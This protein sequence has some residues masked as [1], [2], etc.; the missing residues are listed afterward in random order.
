M[1][2]LIGT[3]RATPRSTSSTGCSSAPTSPAATAIG[4]HGL[5]LPAATVLP[6]GVHELPVPR[7]RAAARLARCTRR[8]GERDERGPDLPAGDGQRQ[9]H[10]RRPGDAGHRRR[11]GSTG[12][13]ASTT[14]AAPQDMTYVAEEVP[15]LGPSPTSGCSRP[16]VPGASRATRRAATAPPTSRCRRRTCSA[17]PALSGYFAPSESQVPAGGRPAARR[18]TSLTTSPGTQKLRLI[19]S[20]DEYIT[21]VPVRVSRPGVLAGGRRGRPARCPGVAG[22]QAVR[23]A[24]P[25][26]TAA[27]G[28]RRRRPPGDRVAGD[29]TA[30]CSSG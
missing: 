10:A 18:S 19:N 6:A 4:P 2:S 26:A 24:P 27:P 14:R 17:T 9:G 16:G 13:S 7:H 28:H 11:P 25:V 30:R 21:R 29:A 1:K 8:L 12:C 22:L 23:H 20:P 15:R 3:G 5:R